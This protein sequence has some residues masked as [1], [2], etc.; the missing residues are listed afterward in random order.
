MRRPGLWVANGQPDDTAQMLSWK[1][2][3]ITCL[4]HHLAANDIFNY[5]AANPDAAINVR[6]AHPR[7]WQQDLAG[8]A[9]RLGQFIA[10]KWAELEPLDPYVFF[11]CRLNTHYE[12]G[13]PNP[14]N[15]R[16]Y[17]TPEFYQ[18]YA[19]WVRTTADVIKSAVPDMK[20]VAPPLAFGLNEDG[21]PD[22]QGNPTKGWAGYDYL[23][24]TIRDYFDGRLAFQ[25]YWGTPALGAVPDWLYEP[26]L[27]SWYAFRWQRVLELFEN[28]YQL[29][30]QLIIDEAGSF[31]PADPDFT[32]QLIYYAQQCLSDER[33]IS[34]SYA[35]WANPAKDP[36]YR[37]NAWVEHIPDLEHHLERLAAMPDVFIIESLDEAG[38]IDL[39]GLAEA[40]D[41]EPPVEV[42]PATRE[43]SIRV[44]FEDGHVETMLLE[45]YLRAVVP[46]EMPAS[47]PIEA[48][49]A[50]AIASRSYAQYAIEHPKFPNADI[51]TTTQCQHYDPAKIH[52]KSDR[53]IAETRG[54]VLRHEGQT[55]NAVFS[56]NCGGHTR[57]NEDVWQ[58]RP[59]IYLRG[60]SCPDT[61]DKSGHGVGLC[62]YGARAL[63][64]SGQTHEQILEHYYQGAVLGS[65]PTGD[66]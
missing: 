3:A 35:L 50:Q 10:G 21:N 22:S 13:D 17:T 33:V 4:Y 1:P 57:N 31:G 42:Q 51:C 15:Q 44:L 48:V 61:G 20:L 60:V 18:R 43:R 54:I 47:W 64:R 16:R 27:S 63:A 6:F 11:A 46:A 5:K 2:G 36:L 62:Q 45:T 39:S 29:E 59:E 28:R 58:G 26:G 24:E 38:L 66:V 65:I 40:V 12:N 32:D 9:Q 52:A 49:K 41:F 25:G 55:I 8:S 14:A 34:L 37:S 19:L 30:A 56:A 23:H 53:A 7:D